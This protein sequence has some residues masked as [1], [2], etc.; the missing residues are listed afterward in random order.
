MKDV[1][2][3]RPTPPGSDPSIGAGQRIRRDTAGHDP[4]C[5]IAAIGAGFAS[6]STRLG[7][8][9]SA[10]ACQCIPADA[11][12][13]D[14]PCTRICAGR[15][16]V[17]TASR[18]VA[19]CRTR[20]GRRRCQP[21]RRPGRGERVPERR[22]TFGVTDR[23]HGPRSVQRACQPP[24]ESSCSSRIPGSQSEAVTEA[25]IAPDSS[26]SAMASSGSSPAGTTSTETTSR[27]LARSPSSGPLSPPRRARRERASAAARSAARPTMID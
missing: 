1:R 20:P 24:S 10:A 7:A 5:G 2:R 8:T 4:P 14:G 27:A 25:A 15:T 6:C 11:S 3:T 22:R 13:E 19:A 21:R 12:I 18:V 16:R 17:A 23:S 26:G 9:R